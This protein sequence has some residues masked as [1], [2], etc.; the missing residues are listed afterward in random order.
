[1][2]APRPVS[3]A[4]LENTTPLFRPLTV[5]IAARARTASWG[6]RLAATALLARSAYLVQLHVLHAL[7]VPSQM[8]ELQGVRIALRVP[9]RAQEPPSA[10]LALL[11]AIPMALVACA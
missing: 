3:R 7:R 4:Q 10:A 2:R 5:L 11:V 9:H 8:L 6:L 1:M